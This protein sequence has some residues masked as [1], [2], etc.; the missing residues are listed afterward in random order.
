MSRGNPKGNV[1]ITSSCSLLNLRLTPET[2][3][4]KI[5]RTRQHHQ[6]AKPALWIDFD[7]IA[8]AF[9]Q[10]IPSQCIARQSAS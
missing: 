5:C 1:W 3:D 6:S 2:A 8:F 10:L 9:E 7:I 4:G